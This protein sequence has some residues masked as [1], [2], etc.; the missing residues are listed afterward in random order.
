MK[1][2][3]SLPALGLCVMTGCGSA[4]GT[5]APASDGIATTTQAEQLSFGG[6]RDVRHV[7]LISVDGLHTSDAAR[8]IAAHPDSTL[9]ELAHDGVEYTDAHTPTPSDSF[10]GLV[11]L[12]TG[13]TPKTTGVYY[14]DSYDRTLFPPGS[15]CQGKPGTE[16]TY[17]EILEKDF[18]QLFSPIDPGNL[19]LEKD[20]RGNCNP[21]FPHDFIKVNTV[22]EVIRAAGGYTAWSDKHPAYDLVN[23]PSGKGIDDLY[24]PEINSLIVN[25]GTANGI[26]LAG[27]LAKCDGTT[28][29]LPLSKVTDYTTCEPSVIAY[30]DVKV[31][32]VINQI[33]GKTSDGTRRAPVPTILGMNFQQVSVGQK[34][35]MGGYTDADGTPSALLDGAIAHVDA[36]LGRMVSELKAKRLYDSTLF[37]VTSKHGQSPIDRGKLSMEKGG[38]GNAT[39]TDPLGFVNA[40]DPNVDQKF[41]SFV[42]P[43]DGSS[44]VVDGHLQTDDVGILWLQE[45]SVSA[46]SGVVSQLTNPTHAA[47]I[48]ANTL[49]PGTIF[50]ANVNSGAELAAIFGDPLSRDPVA[51]ARAPNVFIQPN[52][53]V[54]Y[55]GSNKKVSE[56]GGGTLDDTSVALI[57]SNPGIRHRTIAEHVWTKQVAPTI[58]RAL[59]LDPA[60]L[61]AV[62]KENTQSLP[63]LGL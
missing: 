62:R 7:V 31:R 46:V 16:A 14:D 59:D 4:P 18:T 21:V 37:I 54:I 11:A 25:G 35:P 19:P 8:W 36:S 41:A 29:S 2:R 45:Q 55:S 30:D 57:V 58:L 10:P 43:N 15:A 61:E 48:F 42:N 40:V 13:G 33:D 51:A 60:A 39:V 24:T 52:W 44:P 3:S 12:V 49:P 26:D 50:D 1:I 22:F 53:G 17:F 27:S 28:N 32:A 63:G 56:H 38:L 5:G 47:A 6:R 9:A 23:G 34:L 20:R